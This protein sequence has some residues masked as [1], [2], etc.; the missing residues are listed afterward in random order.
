MGVIFSDMNSH[1]YMVSAEVQAACFLSW[2]GEGEPL[3][4]GTL[5][6]KIAWALPEAWPKQGDR[7]RRAA[8][9]LAQKLRKAGWI[10]HLGGG[11]WTLT[12]R[13]RNGVAELVAARSEAQ[14]SG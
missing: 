4:Y 2:A 12:D 1:G 10:T 5:G 13:G 11:K 9:R 8:D 14:A 7:G 6:A 3:H